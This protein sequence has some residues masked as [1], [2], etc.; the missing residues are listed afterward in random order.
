MDEMFLKKK[1]RFYNWLGVLFMVLIYLCVCFA[2][3]WL[4]FTSRLY[5]LNLNLGYYTP[6]LLFVAGSFCNFKSWKYSKMLASVRGI[7][8]FKLGLKDQF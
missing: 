3:Q 7:S 6:V 4:D 5:L 8:I 1:I 2:D